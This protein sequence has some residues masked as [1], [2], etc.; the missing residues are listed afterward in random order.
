MVTNSLNMK[1]AMIGLLAIYIQSCHSQVRIQKCNLKAAQAMAQERFE[2]VFLTKPEHI[3]HVDS[4]ELVYKFTW[5]Y[6]LSE[7]K[8]IEGGEGVIEISRSE[9]RIIS[10]HYF[11]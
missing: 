6:V 11:Q 1:I 5:E 2:R 9:C 4:S 10:E 3:I 8:Y 7:G